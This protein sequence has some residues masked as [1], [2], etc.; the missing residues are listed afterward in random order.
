LKK[1]DDRTALYDS[2]SQSYYKTDT[3]DGD[4]ISVD[5]DSQYD[6]QATDNFNNKIG[7][8]IG[9]LQECSNIFYGY[10]AQYGGSHMNHYRGSSSAGT[11]RSS[12][13]T[14]EALNSLKNDYNNLNVQLNSIC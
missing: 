12:G 10:I 8:G 5:F 4:F 11:P 2:F 9:R 14:E 13:V 7:R 1:T 6:I 3:K